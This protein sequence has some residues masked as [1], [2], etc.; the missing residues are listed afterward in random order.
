MFRL[1]THYVDIRG[2]LEFAASLT[3]YV[4]LLASTHLLSHFKQ[5]P[6]SVGTACPPFSL[7]RSS[8]YGGQSYTMH[9]T[10]WKPVSLLMYSIHRHSE[11]LSGF[12]VSP[13]CEKWWRLK[14][15]FLFAFA[16]AWGV[17]RIDGARGKKQVWCTSCSNL[18]YFGSKCTA[19][20]TVLMTFLGTF[21]RPPPHSDSEPGELFPPCHP[22]YAPGRRC[23]K[24]F[25]CCNKRN[26]IVLLVLDNGQERRELIVFYGVREETKI[27]HLTGK[28]ETGDIL[29]G[30]P[31]WYLTQVKNNIYCAMAFRVSSKCTKVHKR[32]MK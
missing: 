3:L 20:K 23:Y 4:L 5:Q 24:H 16:V 22:R 27:R 7:Q 15:H 11:H 19:L 14:L 9:S 31:L 32:R 6:S 10:L 17:M 1:P 28:M 30:A 21:L 12:H 29:S 26:W 18:M 8:S 13:G 25:M 2:I